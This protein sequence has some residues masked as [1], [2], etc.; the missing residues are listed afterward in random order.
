[1]NKVKH[2]G[3]TFSNQGYFK[4]V[5]QSGDSVAAEE[6]Q[7]KQKEQEDFERKLVVANKHFFVNTKVTKHQ[8]ADKYKSILKD[9]VSKVGLRLNQNR[10]T[11]MA[12]R[13]IAA[14]KSLKEFPV[15][16]LMKEQ[17]IMNEQAIKPIK[18]QLDSTKT[19]YNRAI[20][21]NEVKD[22]V[23]YA[24]QNGA[25]THNPTSRIPIRPLTKLEKT[26]P[27]FGSNRKHAD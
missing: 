16:S 27:K 24:K 18:A 15:S 12:G 4:T 26:G 17:Y 20:G 22:F 9:P 2:D 13:Q 14:T 21:K 19:P 10:L 3:L 8:Q 25:V 11:Q 23:R 6:K 7:R 1:M 5:F